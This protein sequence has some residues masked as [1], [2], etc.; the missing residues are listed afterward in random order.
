MVGVVG[1]P[2]AGPWDQ[3]P[4]SERYVSLVSKSPKYAYKHV[5]FIIIQV[6]AMTITR[7]VDISSSQDISYSNVFLKRFD[8]ATS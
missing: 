1:V 6:F 5:M 2:V 7:L 3:P 8:V 4:K